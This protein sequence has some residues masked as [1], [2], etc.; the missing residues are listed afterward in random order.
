MARC[1][2]CKRRQTAG[3]FVYGCARTNN[4]NLL[5]ESSR[6]GSNGGA[7]RAQTMYRT[8]GSGEWTARP[9]KQSDSMGVMN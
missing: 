8:R 9:L 5:E 2:A 4:R 3:H 6:D 1:V 7:P